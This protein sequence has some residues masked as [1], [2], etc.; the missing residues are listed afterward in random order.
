MGQ[1]DDPRTGLSQRFEAG[2]NAPDPRVVRYRPVGKRYIQI[3]PDK[4]MATCG[5]HFVDK[6]EWRFHWDLPWQGSFAASCCPR[7]LADHAITD[8]TS[9][10]KAVVWQSHSTLNGKTG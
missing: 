3:K 10:A 7:G 5:F 9:P 8:K 2:Q 6:Q 1:Y 4:A